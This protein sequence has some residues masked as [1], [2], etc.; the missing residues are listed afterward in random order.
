M[1][2]EVSLVVRWE[3]CPEEFRKED[4]SCTTFGPFTP[5]EADAFRAQHNLGTGKAAVVRVWNAGGSAIPVEPGA[6]HIMKV[7]LADG[8]LRNESM[9]LNLRAIKLETA[10]LSKP[11]EER[12]AF[13]GEAAELRKAAAAKAEAGE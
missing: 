11:Q 12:V 3:F 5:E 10:A 4:M 13:K 1:Q 7:A 2:P 9:E 8:M 6:P